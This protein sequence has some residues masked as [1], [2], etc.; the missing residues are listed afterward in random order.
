MNI[1]IVFAHPNIDSF[2]GAMRNTAVETL[3]QLGHQVTTADLFQSNFKASADAQDFTELYNS[4]FFDIQVEQSAATQRQT[5][6]PDIAEQH[7]LLSQADLIIFQFP[8]WWY[9]MPAPLKGYIDRV[10]SMGWAYGGGKAL[11]GK[12]IL[13]ST[14]TGAPEFAWTPD[15]RG[16]VKENFKHLFVGT[17]ELVG[18]QAFE[19][20][21]VYGAKRLGESE[22]SVELDK[23][24]SFLKS[25]V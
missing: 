7:Q 24:A 9:S 11:A 22:R 10:F 19:P 15:K 14:T 17:F 25:I 16:T 2:N 18:L 5:F 12:K 3:Q 21:I 8:L 23:Y 20:Y 6:T 13:V 1:H 4:D